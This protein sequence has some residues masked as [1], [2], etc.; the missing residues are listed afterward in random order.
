MMFSEARHTPFEL[1]ERSLGEL[2]VSADSKT[3]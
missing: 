2:Q 1:L 3:R